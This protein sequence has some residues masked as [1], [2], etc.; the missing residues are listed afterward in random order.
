MTIRG[1]GQK[2]A[3]NFQN[4]TLDAG[5]NL[6]RFA[7]P[8]LRDCSRFPIANAASLRTVPPSLTLEDR[9]Y[10][11]DSVPAI[12]KSRFTSEQKARALERVSQAMRG[13]SSVRSVADTW[14]G[15]QM[16]DFAT[17]TP[18][19]IS[20]KKFPLARVFCPLGTKTPKRKNFSF[21]YRVM[22]KIRN[23]ADSQVSDVAYEIEVD[24]SKMSWGDK[25]IFDTLQIFL[26]R[27]ETFF[28]GCL[29]LMDGPPLIVADDFAPVRMSGKVLLRVTSSSFSDYSLE[30]MNPR[31]RCS[32]G[33]GLGE[34]EREEFVQGHRRYQSYV[35]TPWEKLRWK[36]N[37]E[38]EEGREVF[39]VFYYLHDRYHQFDQA[40]LPPE[41]MALSESLREALLCVE[42]KRGP[43]L[44]TDLLLKRLADKELFFTLGISEIMPF[45]WM[46]AHGYFIYSVGHSDSFT[47]AR[48]L[49]KEVS[50]QRFFYF[51]QSSYVLKNL[52]SLSLGQIRAYYDFVRDVREALELVKDPTKFEAE[53]FFRDLE[54]LLQRAIFKKERGLPLVTGVDLARDLLMAFAEALRFW[55]AREKN[56]RGS[57]NETFTKPKKIFL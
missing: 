22:E 2:I 5:A 44:V 50:P 32:T 17:R 9:R 28:E 45:I 6:F 11:E 20:C 46:T 41:Y 25:Y 42:K 3:F 8:D 19:V 52:N 43:A 49:F 12:Q 40:L 14:L 48:F 24:T 21:Q 33:Y 27:M 38:R 37:Y 51:Q 1:I 55:R 29:V 35:A 53:R 57:K 47:L 23:E 15:L 18:G 39:E 54:R 4:F 13:K 34:L 56:D 26:G 36:D 7:N 31:K 30:M 16:S 10:L